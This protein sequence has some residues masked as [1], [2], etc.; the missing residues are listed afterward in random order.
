MK[1]YKLQKLKFYFSIIYISFI[2]YRNKHQKMFMTLGLCILSLWMFC[3]VIFKIKYS[4]FCNALLFI[5]I[6]LLLLINY[7]NMDKK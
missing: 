3:E 2:N 1:L 6:T 7:E 5:C 4:I